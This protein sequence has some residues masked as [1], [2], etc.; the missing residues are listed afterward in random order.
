V[1]FVLVIGVALAAGGLLAVSPVAVAGAACA[2]VYLLRARLRPWCVALAMIALFA[3]GVRARRAIAADAALRAK[4][5]VPRVE[6]DGVATIS[7]SPVLAGGTVRATAEFEGTCEGA[8]WSGR[9]QLYELNEDAAR[10]DRLGVRA[11]LGR[12]ERFFNTQ[13][14]GPRLAR[15][16][17]LRSGRVVDAETIGPGR[18]VA[19]LVD[20]ARAHVRRRI[21]ATFTAGT[22]PLARALVLGETDLTQADDAAF[23]VSGLSH[24]L[25]V[26]GMHLVLVVVALLALLRRALAFVPF[27]AERWDVGR[28]VAAAG[29]PLSW[30]YA[31]FAGGSGSAIRAAYMLSVALGARALRRRPDGAR[32]LGW[33]VLLLAAFDPLVAFDVSFVLSAAATAGLLAFARPLEERLARRLPRFA[34]KLATPVATTLAATIACAPVIAVFAPTLPVGGV[35]ANLIAVPVGELAALP[36]CL[37]HALLEWVPPV[38]RG[39]A[40]AAS[41][42]LGFV[43]AVARVFSE[44][45]WMS[46]EVPPPSP[47]QLGALVAG[48]VALRLRRWR[49]AMAALVVVLAVEAGLRVA[50]HRT[51]RLSVTFLDV[52]QGD[53]AFVSL[54]DGDAVLIDGGGLVGSPVDVGDLVVAPF[55]RG[56]RRDRLRAVLLSHPHPD[57]YL[58][59]A[60]GT[61]RVRVDEM[62]DTGQ[63]EQEALDGAHGELLRRLRA[64]GVVVRYAPELC[65]ER[66]IGGARFEVL[67]PCPGPLSDRGPND[68]SLVVRI[69]YRERS[70]LFVGDAEHIEEDA[71]L[72]SSGERL[73]A[74]VLKVGH[75]G[76][77]TSSQPVFLAR[78]RPAHAVISV[79]A[80]N[81]FGH[82]SPQTLE[83]LAAVGARTWRTDRD[84]AVTATTDGVRLEVRA[85]SR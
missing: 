14:P 7:S 73:R 77:R 46:L 55:L 65:G 11:R 76:S 39:C 81:G 16:G 42:A 35:V 47:A 44:P 17:V 2:L 69:S 53:A 29:V 12:V 82:P 49:A 19:A 10:G 32:A 67:A 74:D 23:R 85:A 54:P 51:G 15:R 68:N 83:A 6:C 57:H 26:S 80:R 38:E 34:R 22:E 8:R 24:L 27:V 20:R 84:G 5:N 78:V 79:G 13:D 9:V 71:L 3:G 1:D 62:W 48:L 37:F 40:I 52:G 63:G 28:A 41:G 64:R 21:L 18:G 60:S 25:A 70:F 31:D 59:L 66:E 56:A 58:G 30:A 75:H 50:A 61:A 36:M 33:S 43:R 45:A 4:E 72:A